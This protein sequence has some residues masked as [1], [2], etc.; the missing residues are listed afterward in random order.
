MHVLC[1][2]S[3]ARIFPG[4]RCFRGRG[5]GRDTKVAG[6]APSPGPKN[7]HPERQ[8][9]VDFQTKFTAA[10]PQAEDVRQF[11]ATPLAKDAVTYYTARPSSSRQAH[12]SCE[13]AHLR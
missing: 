5:G 9:D 12:C 8:H 1:H 10:V 2:D 13:I 4:P 7:G 6:N 3:I 11:L